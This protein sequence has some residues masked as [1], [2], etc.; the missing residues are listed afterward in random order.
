MKFKTI[1]RDGPARI[2]DLE[3][4]DKRITTP[5]ILFLDT[6]RFKAPKFADIF[7]SNIKI[8][9]IK[10][11]FE[12]TEKILLQKLI[13]NDEKDFYLINPDKPLDN[14]IINNSATIFIVVNA[15]QL[16]NQSKKFVEFIVDLREK[17]GY[18]KLIYLPSIAK[19]E[20]LL[21][22][23]YL[24]IDL[25]DSIQAIISARN[26]TMLFETGSH[27]IDELGEIPCNC[28]SCDKIDKKPSEMNFNEILQHNYHMYDNEIKRVRNSISKG[29]LRNL[30]ET[31]VK[32]DPNLSA[33][34][35]NLDANHY[36]FLEKRTP[37]IGKNKIFATT[38]ESLNRPGIKRFQ[39]RVT[40]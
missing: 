19:P 14:S 1:K 2:G 9:S 36:N 10:P 30:V 32:L 35:R 17:I 12:F 40:T 31:K 34:L 27:N 23:S 13:K 11:K 20:N 38:N 4:K 39:E 8:D 18:Q 22:L 33:I 5:N 21:L 3:L 28:P 37:I 15:L 29:N 16:F 6:S 25:F 26:K 24:G 7:I